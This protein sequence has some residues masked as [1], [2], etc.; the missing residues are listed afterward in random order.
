MNIKIKQIR[1][2]RNGISGEGF[3]AVWFNCDGEDL[4]A[5]I[6]SEADT[7]TCR[8][9]DPANPAKAYRGDRIGMALVKRMTPKVMDSFGLHRI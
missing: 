2:N 5:T 6:N 3:Y 9:L 1:F 4:L 7:T 8:V